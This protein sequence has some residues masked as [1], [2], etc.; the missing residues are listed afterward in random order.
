MQ[1]HGMTYGGRPLGSRSL[2]SSR[3]FEPL[4]GPGKPATGRRETGSKDGEPREDTKCVTER[5]LE[6]PALKT[7]ALLESR[8]R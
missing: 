4:Q 8:V 3:G 7:I 6:I 5:G 2:R 1:K